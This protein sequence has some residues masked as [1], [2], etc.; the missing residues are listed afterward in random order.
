MATIEMSRNHSL[1]TTEASRRVRILVDDFTE[2]R[3]ELIDTV[4]WSTD[5]CS[6]VAKGKGFTARFQVDD[7][8]AQIEVDLSLMLRPFKKKVRSRLESKLDEVFE[9]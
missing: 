9:L 5:G 8:T 4:D 1:G 2:Q 3:K 7:S 6:A